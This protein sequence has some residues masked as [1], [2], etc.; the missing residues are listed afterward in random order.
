M[1]KLYTVEQASALLSV[2]SEPLRQWLR[3]GRVRGV[4]MGHRSWRVPEGALN[5]IASAGLASIDA[6]RTPMPADATLDDFLAKA[7]ALHRQLDA[8]G[9]PGIDG[10]EAVQKVREA[11]T[12]QLSGKREED[13]G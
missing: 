12:R 11:R 10:A 7:E 2:H 13:A 5:E 1:E 6:T 9:F 8:A 3:S 4:K